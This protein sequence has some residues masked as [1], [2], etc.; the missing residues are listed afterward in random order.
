MRV[1]FTIIFLIC[2][3]SHAFSQCASPITMLTENFDGPSPIT[4][5]ITSNIYGGGSWTNAAY[6]ISGPAHG[7][8][9][10]QNGLSNVDVY[11]RQLTG[12][13]PDSAVAISLWTRHSFGVTNVTFSAIDDF[14]TVLATS[15][16]NLTTVFQQIVFN[17]NATTPG[18]RFVI[19]CNST[20]GNGVDI[21]VED[22]VVTHCSSATNQ[23]VNLGLCSLNAPI[24]LFA[25]FSASILGGGTWSG[26]TPL[27]NGIL[28]TFDPLVNTDGVY[29]YTIAGSCSPP[30]TVT[31]EIMGDIDLGLDTTICDGANVLL[32]AGAGFDNYL[33][34]TGATTS[35]INVT[36]P[37]TYSVS[38]ESVIGD[39]IVNGDFELGNTGF[40]T[41]YT[42]GIGGAWGPLSNPG[43]YAI[44]T[45][46]SLVH[47]NFSS[48]GDHTTGVGNML[49]VN[50]SSTANTNVWC[51]NVIVTPNTDYEFSA[52]IAN[53]LNDP[54]VANLQFYVNGAAIG[55]IFT[56]SVTGCVW[57]QYSDNW[58][59]GAMTN[60]T[61]CIVN[62]NTAGSGNDF[63]LDD[64][65]F[66]PTCTKVDT[67]V[68]DVQVPVQSITLT[69]PLCAGDTN[70]E[71]HVDNSEATEYN[72]DGGL[73]QVDSFF[74][75]LGQGTYAVCS[76][77]SI[78][79]TVCEDVVLVDPV[80]VSITVSNDTT[81][82]E[83][84][85]ATL[86]AFGAGGTVYQYHWGFTADL[87]AVQMVNPT[88]PTTYTVFVENENGCIS[89]D[90]TINVA[91]FPPLTGTISMIDTICPG[92]TV[93]VSATAAGGQ[94]QPYTF[95]W[96]TGVSYTGLGQHSLS[97]SPSITTSYSVTISDGCES[98][99]INLITTV[100]VADL[101]IVAI[102]VLN[103]NQCEPGVF[104][105]VNSST[106]SSSSFTYWLVG[107]VHQ[108][109]NQD[110]ITTPGLMHGDYDVQLIVGS[111]E[112]CIDSLTITDLLH[113]DPI[114]VADFVYS[115][116]PITMFNSQV[117]FSNLSI[118]ASTY[119]WYF[120]QGVPAQSIAENPT[121]VF[122]D[123]QEGTY[124]VMLIAA[125]DL[126]CLDTAFLDVI[127]YSE[128][129]IYAPNAFTPDGDE[130][131][132]NWFVHMEGIDIYDFE[133][134]LFNRWGE[135]V[136]ESHDI[137]VG[138]DGTYNG[139]CAQVGTYT[140]VV[141]A[142]DLFNDER[143]VFNGHVTL[144]K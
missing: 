29:S 84:G 139:N 140:W 103:P 82:C 48:C 142:K 73:W 137:S 81:I 57:E 131:N 11:D 100:H 108:F 95:D 76:R 12:F 87:G 112:G 8:F 60:V 104:T 105:I 101:P 123:G 49:V 47:N 117:Y 7:W 107:G 120:D 119:E 63:A 116:N 16:L 56:T 102:T 62:Q 1:L 4:G 93:D 55:S 65:H 24:D 125:S 121:T 129:L 64:I 37:G 67:I 91:V 98:T 25:Q 126:G 33:W 143:H 85:T 18:L 96:D 19:H 32:S 134:Q 34:N 68:V 40:T 75:N 89:Q 86:E 27:S 111:L 31:I 92:E 30:S 78:G 3:G 54:N 124:Q 90:A 14:G 51:Q 136:W 141:H 15:T 22:I 58:N 133:L 23:N 128:I 69:Q 99:P 138:W 6:I 38:V 17:F 83:N 35:D 113:V 135:L 53:A 97:V 41:A 39:I 72:L 28:G 70:G 50:G 74:V 109:I 106:P 10:V 114:P 45:S 46:P 20:G 66:G 144:L 94:G 71:I 59:S 77:S 80:A 43:T 21:V 118:N 2:I 132:Q 61:L 5:A 122:P 127:V 42:L 13:C 79:C 26:P 9:N 44:T 88:V 36:L 115:P 130:H 52:W 110:T